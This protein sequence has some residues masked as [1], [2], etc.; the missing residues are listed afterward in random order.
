MDGISGISAMG[1]DYK[2]ADNDK[3]LREMN[4]CISKWDLKSLGWRGFQQL[5]WVSNI[6]NKYP[7]AEHIAHTCSSHTPGYLDQVQEL[8][9]SASSVEDKKEIHKYFMGKLGLE[10]LSCRNSG[11]AGGLCDKKRAFLEICR[12]TTELCKG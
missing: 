10:E 2:M 9:D 1:G 11:A 8:M 7:D 6:T 5:D 3:V 4:K 12:L